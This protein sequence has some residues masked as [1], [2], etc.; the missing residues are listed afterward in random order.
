VCLKRVSNASNHYVVELVFPQVN[1]PEFLLVLDTLT[2]RIS[3]LISEGVLSDVKIF[4]LF[5][6]LKVRKNGANTC[7]ILNEV[8]FKSQGG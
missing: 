2:K 6:S 4:K 3:Y 7:L 8:T 1:R 5:E